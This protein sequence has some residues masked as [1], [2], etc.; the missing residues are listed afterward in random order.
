MNDTHVMRRKP[1]NKTTRYM[2]NL[3]IYI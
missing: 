3:I 1:F 2:F